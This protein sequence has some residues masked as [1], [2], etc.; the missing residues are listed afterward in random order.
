MGIEYASECY[1]GNALSAGSVLT[2]SGCSM[3][4]SGNSSEYC[5]GP[6]R[7]NF[8]TANSAKSLGSTTRVAATTSSTISPVSTPTDPI[9]I[10]G[11]ANFTYLGCYVEPANSRALSTLV[12]DK[13]QMTVEICLSACSQYIYAGLEYRRCV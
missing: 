1:C 2:A 5:G 11:D 13:P 8:Y 4:C 12:L 7:L 6:N 10:P 3:T 9:I